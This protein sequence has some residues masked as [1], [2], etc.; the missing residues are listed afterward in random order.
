MSEC[1]NLPDRVSDRGMAGTWYGVWQNG[2]YAVARAAE[3]AAYKNTE[4]VCIFA[5]TYAVFTSE[6]GGFAGEVLPRMREQIWEN[7]LKDA[8]FQPDSEVEIEV[9]HLFPR[10][11]RYDEIWIPI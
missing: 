6:K 7:A 10:Q 11:E 5:G 1:E 4:D 8:G 3:E 2:R 9:Y